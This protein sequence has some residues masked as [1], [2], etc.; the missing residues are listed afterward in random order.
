MKHEQSHHHPHAALNSTSH[1][2]IACAIWVQLSSGFNFLQP[3]SNSAIAHDAQA[4]LSLGQGPVLS[5]STFTVLVNFSKPVVPF[6]P[7]SVTVTGAVLST[8]TF[9][10]SST[11]ALMVLQVCEARMTV[12]VGMGEILSG[13]TYMT[14]T[15]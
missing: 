7:S 12:S 8:V 4:S 3:L 5:N 6:Q 2:I 14:V 11:S 1:A 9:E 13:E 15:A 10:P